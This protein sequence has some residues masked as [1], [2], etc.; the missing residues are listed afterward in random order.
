MSTS[1]TTAPSSFRSRFVPMLPWLPFV[2]GCFAFLYT[3]VIAIT[4]A[5]DPPYTAND[6]WQR[7][8]IIACPV[9]FV[10]AALLAAFVRRRTAAGIMVAA[11]LGM[12]SLGWGVV[13]WDIPTL[14]R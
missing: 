8:A 6:G 3:V 14:F 1:T 11:G 12:C 5:G 7:A 13:H 9:L 2:G 4:E 10:V